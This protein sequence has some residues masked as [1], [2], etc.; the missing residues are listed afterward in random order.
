[1][2]RSAAFGQLPSSAPNWV[3]GKFW[4]KKEEK[5]IMSRKLWFFSVVVVAAFVFASSVC[6]Q[7]ESGLRGRPRIVQG[8][9]EADRVA[10][11]GN[12][13]PEARPASKNSRC[14]SFSTNFKEKV[15]QTFIAG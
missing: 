15:R 2:I 10:L 8:I 4:S 13:H 3:C 9:N 14:S 12:T 1:L 5:P 11:T 7:I 6:A